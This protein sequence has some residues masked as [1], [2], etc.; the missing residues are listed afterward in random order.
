MKALCHLIRVLDAKTVFVISTD[1][2]QFEIEHQKNF[3][4][5]PI[6]L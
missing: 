4:N 5:V 3:L 6:V 2:K 1:F